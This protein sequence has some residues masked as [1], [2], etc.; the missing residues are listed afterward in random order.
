MNKILL[1]SSL[2]LSLNIFAFDCSELVN[3][4]DKK[5]DLV[6]ELAHSQSMEVLDRNIEFVSNKNDSKSINIK[7]S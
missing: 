5:L 6:F 4:P 7:K 3:L 2:L 1:M